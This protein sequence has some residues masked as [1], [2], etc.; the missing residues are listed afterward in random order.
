LSL[1]AADEKAAY[2]LMC[3]EIR[4]YRAA[5]LA[6]RYGCGS[7]VIEWIR[8]CRRCRAATALKQ[9]PLLRHELEEIAKKLTDD[10]KHAERIVYRLRDDLGWLHEAFDELDVQAATP[11]DDRERS[12]FVYL[13][14][15]ERA[16]KI[17]WSD[18]HPRGRRLSQLQSAS[19]EKLKVLGLIVGTLSRERQLHRRFARHW[20]RGEWF[21][22]AEEIL[23]YFKE[24]GV[25]V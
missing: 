24:H 3:G 16:V 15:H 21:S 14:G 1:A 8:P 13:V 11:P 4:E 25:P 2:E 7:E 12:G 18:R 20:I 6:H 19:S 9:R 10:L 5:E 17:G 22:P 23:A